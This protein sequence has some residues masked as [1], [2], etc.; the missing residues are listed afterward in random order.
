MK[1]DPTE[2]KEAKD[3]LEDGLGHT[4]QAGGQGGADRG[5]QELGVGE[6]TARNDKEA[7]HEAE[8][9]VKI[10][11]W[12]AYWGRLPEDD[13]QGQEDGQ[14][15][16]AV[17]VDHLQDAL[18]ALLGAFLDKREVTG[19]WIIHTLNATISKS[20]ERVETKIIIRGPKFEIWYWYSF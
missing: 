2:C 18:V 19:L 14:R 12:L 9:G 7:E 17:H 16:V 3:G 6:H 4:H 15:V 1:L 10:V 5:A 11:Q 13:A 8:L 20:K